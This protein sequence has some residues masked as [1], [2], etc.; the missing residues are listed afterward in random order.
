VQVIQDYY[1]AVTKLNNLKASDYGKN[2]KTNQIEL[3]E[4]EVE[5]LKAKAID[6]KTAIDSMVNPHTSSMDE[7]KSYQEVMKLFD[8]ASQGSAE[9]VA[10]LKD[11]MAKVDASKVQ[12]AQSIIEKLEKD[13]VN[14]ENHPIEIRQNDNYKAKL[15]ELRQSLKDIKTLQETPITESFDAKTKAAKLDELTNSAQKLSTELKNMASFEKGANPTSIGKWIAK[16]GDYLNDNTRISEDAKTKLQ[17]YIRVLQ[18][19]GVNAPLEE[20]KNGFYD[21][22]NAEKLA[23]REGKSLIDIFKSKAL[24]NNIASIASMYFSIYRVIGYIKESIN[25]IVDLD[26]ALVDLQKTTTMTTSELNEF[27]Y[28]SNDVAK[29]MGVTTEEI[30][31][32]ASAWSRLNKIGLLYSNV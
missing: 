30:I 13:L 22:T 29:Q 28:S 1:D 19:Q 11:A 21:I 4:A 14:L 17:E 31:E 18:T 25:T 9:S 3:Q 24:Y 10:K 5:K 12:T 8:Q 32:Q 20:I 27:Y 26:T 2:Q 16:I 23:G 6:A 15:D 7:W